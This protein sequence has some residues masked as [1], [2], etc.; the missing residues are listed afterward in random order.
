MG[1]DHDQDATANLAL[2]R[3]KS[4]VRDMA[5]HLH[6]SGPITI[7][8]IEYSRVLESLQ[9][10]SAAFTDGVMAQT[11][12]RARRLFGVADP[13]PQQCIK[14]VFAHR[15]FGRTKGRIVTDAAAMDMID[16]ALVADSPRVQLFCTGFPMKV[17]NP[18]ETGYRGDA[19]DLG[20]VSV[21]LRF[22]ELAGVLTHFGRDIGK[23]FAVTVVSDGAMNSGMFKTGTL[24]C[25]AYV[26]RLGD[27]IARL[28]IASFVSVTEFYS[29]ITT[30]GGTHRA[31]YDNAVGRIKA[32]CHA[33]FG[34]LL[35]RDDVERGQVLCKPG[36]VT[37]HTKF[38]AE[39]YILTKEEGG[40][41]T[42]FFTNYRPQFYFRT[43]DVTGVVHLP[44]GTEMVMPGDNV[45]MEVEL[46]VPIAMEERLRFA[47]REG[48]RT[49]GAGVVASIIE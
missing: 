12:Q 48:G 23:S 21:L 15:S 6:R 24:A 32:A 5:D 38:K 28:G 4:A 44:E 45:A 40:R 39:A 36:S 8:G 47:I 20:D 46:I 22:A 1:L 2:H 14:A 9:R 29:M 41:H 16:R 13:S 34:P 49:V 27:M 42:P 43:T 10:S 19:V 25:E 17:F 33:A 37:P 18:L 11:R 7:S 26:S 3:T 35:D 31:A 30:A